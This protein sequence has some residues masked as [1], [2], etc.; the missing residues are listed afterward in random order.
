MDCAARGFGEV[1]ALGL[2]PGAELALCKAG[3]K[4]EEI[5]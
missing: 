5:A 3:P 4:V 1:G 2:P